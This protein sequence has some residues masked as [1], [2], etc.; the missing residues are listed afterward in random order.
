MSSDEVVLS[1]RGVSKC[2]E[3][4]EKPIHRLY[5]TLLAGRHRFYREFWAL[6]DISF[7][8]HRGE[9]LAI[10]G[11]NGAGKSTLLQILVG[12]LQATTGTVRTQGRVAALLELGSGFNPEFTGRENVYMNGA[13]LGLSSAEIDARYQEIVDFA[14]I[15]EFIDQPV[16]TYSSGM[17]VRL[18]F[19]VQVLSDPDV[20]I[21]DEALAVGDTAFQR[22]CF[23]RM[24]QLKQK[25]VTLILVTHDT[26]TVKERCDR[27]I[28]PK[29]H[30]VAFDGDTETG[31][32]EYMR[33]MFPQENVPVPLATKAADA[34]RPDAGDGA[35]AEFVFERRD[36]SAD[37]SAWGIGGGLIRAVRIHGLDRPNILRTPSKIRIEV[38]AAWDRNFVAA[39]LREE[40]L[41]ENMM[42]GIR[43]SDVRDVPFYGTNNSLEKVTVD[44]FSSSSAV[45]SYE[46]DLPALM[47]GPL[48][49]TTAVAIGNMDH[50]VNL[51]WNDMTVELV[52]EPRRITGGVFH[53]PTVL[54]ARKLEA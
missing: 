17:M 49:L 29:D 4:Y 12:T 51:V 42:I 24:D 19:A 15:G 33:Y 26:G 27:V 32:S 45:V 35:A 48:F 36:L 25:G 38:E 37:R 20:L 5:Q 9:A 53:C 47:Q 21:V 6:R 7:D 16:K 31:V 2:F 46:L 11:R 14:D 52:S 1:V 50:H 18:A 40:S 22:K 13:I 28:F 3:M 44:P 41:P 30:A 34:V 54:T 10:I 23:M 43:L 39:K 8:V